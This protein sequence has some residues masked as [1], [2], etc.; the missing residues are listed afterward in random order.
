MRTKRK[1]IKIE[2]TQNQIVKLWPF[3][4]AVADDNLAA[5]YPH[6]LAILGQAQAVDK[7]KVTATAEFILLSADEARNVEAVLAGRDREAC[8][9]CGSSATETVDLCE[10]CYEE[11]S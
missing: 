5:N 1:K 4:Q 3:F 6:R 7:G 11:L 9:R 10:R 8:W 2:L